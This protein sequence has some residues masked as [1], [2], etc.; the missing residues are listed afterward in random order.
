[1]LVYSAATVTGPSTAPNSKPTEAE[2][3]AGMDSVL[4]K[5]GAS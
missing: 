5:N 3:S 4:T 2:W 1:M